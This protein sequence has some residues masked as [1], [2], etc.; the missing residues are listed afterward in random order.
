MFLLEHLP[1]ALN[2]HQH[3]FRWKA[4][5]ETRKLRV[6][7]QVGPPLRYISLQCSKF[8]LL[9]ISTNKTFFSEISDSL[10]QLVQLVQLQLM[11]IS[12][13]RVWKRISFCTFSPAPTN[14]KNENMKENSNLP[15]AFFPSRLDST[16]QLVQHQLISLIRVWYPKA[17][18]DVN[19]GKCTWLRHTRLGQNNTRL[20]ART[21]GKQEED[22]HFCPKWVFH[23]KSRQMLIWKMLGGNWRACPL[24]SVHYKGTCKKNSLT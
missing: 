24:S 16:V 15:A 20:E 14:I 22:F 9:W 7:D 11:R 2:K 4:S 12:L 10:I 21:K 18:A 3:S 1:Q 5:R 19:Q 13:I 17:L 23:R 8:S 6:Q